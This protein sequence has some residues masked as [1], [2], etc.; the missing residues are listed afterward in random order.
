MVLAKNTE[1]LLV[2]DVDGVLIDSGG[3]FENCVAMT[4]KEMVPELEWSNELFWK[5]KQ[6]P[7]FNNDFRLTAAAIALFETGEIDLLDDTNNTGFPHMEGRIKELAPL[8][9]ERLQFFYQSYKH[10]ESPLITWPELE[11]IHGWNIA[12]LT[13]RLPEELLMGF[14][15]L[16]FELPAVCDSCPEFCKPEPGGLIHLANIYSANKIY[17]VGDTRD[18]ATCLSRARNARPDLD[19]TFVA[20]NKLRNEIAQPGDLAFA[21]LRDFLASGELDFPKP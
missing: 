4:L 19:F 7:G 18:D 20:V 6:I 14:E 8:C 17:F 3:S 2:L 15:V 11:A 10:L 12:I 9:G 16:G 21:T 5:F 1:Y 13:G